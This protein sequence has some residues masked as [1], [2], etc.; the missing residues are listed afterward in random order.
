MSSKSFVDCKSFIL[1]HTSSAAMRESWETKFIELIFYAV[2][3]H[4]SCFAF[5]M[6]G[7]SLLVKK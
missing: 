2:W 7:R 6:L 5:T 1:N 3:I 4:S